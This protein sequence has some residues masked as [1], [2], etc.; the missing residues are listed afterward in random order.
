MGQKGRKSKTHS[1]LDYETRKSDK[2]FHEGGHDIKKARRPY[3]KAKGANGGDVLHQS[4][5]APIQ[6]RG[7]GKGDEGEQRRATRGA[8]IVDIN[9]MNSLRKWRKRKGFA[10]RNFHGYRGAV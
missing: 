5:W 4:R 9:E 1:G 10:P 6:N 7:F 3:H 2:D 8:K